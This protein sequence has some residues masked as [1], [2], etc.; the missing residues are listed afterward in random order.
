MR[1][2]AIYRLRMLRRHPARGGS[3][4]PTGLR[5]HRGGRG[6]KFRIDSDSS[7]SSETSSFIY[8]LESDGAISLFGGKTGEKSLAKAV[9]SFDPI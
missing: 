5:R 7:I 8:S 6:L 4:G 3:G 9:S 1:R 2:L